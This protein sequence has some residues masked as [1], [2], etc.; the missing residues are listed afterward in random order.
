VKYAADN[1]LEVIIRYL[2]PWPNG[3]CLWAG[4]AVDITKPV[5]EAYNAQSGVPAPAKR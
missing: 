3:Q 4:P 5:V 2:Y 1:G